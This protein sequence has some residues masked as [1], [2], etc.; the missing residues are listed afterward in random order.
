MAA[1]TEEQ[2]VP[3]ITYFLNKRDPTSGPNQMARNQTIPPPI[4]REENAKNKTPPAEAP[5]SIPG[6]AGRF[7]RMALNGS[8]CACVGTSVSL[9]AKPC[10]QTTWKEMEDSQSG[11]L[12]KRLHAPVCH[13]RHNKNS[14]I[15]QQKETQNSEKER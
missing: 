9:Q 14:L 15:L 7:K 3:A 2:T 4:K 10:M 11:L 8:V 5:N 6:V 12:M 1:Q 13:C